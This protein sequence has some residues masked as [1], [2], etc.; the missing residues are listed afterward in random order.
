MPFQ[1][2][3]DQDIIKQFD[4]VI[5][6]GENLTEKTISIETSKN[7]IDFG[8]FK[9][10]AIHLMRYLGLTDDQERFEKRE[11]NKNV[12]LRI[13]LAEGIGALKAIK[14]SYEKGFLSKLTEK[15]ATDAASDYMGQAEQLL[16]EGQSG[17]YD[18]VPAAVLA[19]AVLEN[20]LR[21]L[22]QRQTPPIDVDK[23]D[24]SPKT[25]DPLIADLQKANVYTKA[26]ADQL[27]SWAK[28]RNSAAHG[29]FKEF[30]R[31]EVEAMIKGIKNFL[32]DYL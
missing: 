5:A 6:K 19:G 18:H 30:N 22:C 20:N 24:G 29:K 25:L 23:P 2:K 31:D 7:N 17:Q 21:R 26:K 32:A 15:I 14:D 9:T 3:V 10:G 16:G 13:F 11:D 4:E 1:H 27:R 12:H 28:I 8:E